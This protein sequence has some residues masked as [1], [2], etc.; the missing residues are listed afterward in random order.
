MTGSASEKAIS[1]ASRAFWDRSF[2][3]RRAMFEE[4]RQRSPIEFHTETAGPGFWSIVGYDDVVAVSRNPE[5]FSSAKGFTI[6]DV[7]AEILEFAMSMIAMDDPR[8]RRL[9]GIVQSAF[10]AASVRGIAERV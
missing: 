8:H 2:A 5:A 6:D 3:G 1:P 7:P 10:T 9:R 4:L